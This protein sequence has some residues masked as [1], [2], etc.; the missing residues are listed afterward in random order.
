MKEGRRE[1]RRVGGPLALCVRAALDRYFTDLDGALPEA[2]YDLVIS[3]VE[4]PL[5]EY[6]M[7]KCGRNQCQ[8]AK[9]LGINR[10]TLR[11]KLR[12]YGLS[13]Q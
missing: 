12:L 8:T 13:D 2:L 11:K 6:A 4:A 1:A 7:E 9:L 3:Q 10:N 5:I